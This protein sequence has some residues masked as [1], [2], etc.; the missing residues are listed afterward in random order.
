VRRGGH[1]VAREDVVR[2]FDRSL[3]HFERIY[4]PLADRWS[5]YDNSG[6]RPRLLERGP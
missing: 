6:T 2:R 5:V 1:P 3:E 4:R